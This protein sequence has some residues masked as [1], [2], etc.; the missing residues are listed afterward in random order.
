MG[1]DFF[2]F[3]YHN[4]GLRTFSQYDTRMGKR[5]DIMSA[6]TSGQCNKLAAGG[7]LGVG[8]Y[9][10][11]LIEYDGWEIKDDYPW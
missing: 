4:N 1:R 9:C 10:S 3:T 5:S 2:V 11:T 6:G 7:V 8:S